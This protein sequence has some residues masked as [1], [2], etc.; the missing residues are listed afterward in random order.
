M[1]NSQ[2]TL[3]LFNFFQNKGESEDGLKEKYAKLHFFSFSKLSAAFLTFSACLYF[4][5]MRGL[6]IISTN[7]SHNKC[8]IKYISNILSQYLNFHP[9]LNSFSFYE[10]NIKTI[11]KDKNNAYLIPK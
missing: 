3:P 8:L 6:I 9:I 1:K 10:I 11:F 2:T 5:N 7:Q 4:L